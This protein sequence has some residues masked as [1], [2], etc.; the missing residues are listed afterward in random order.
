MTEER[1][2]PYF[3]LALG[4]WTLYQAWKGV[5]PD[6]FNPWGN[7]ETGLHMRREQRMLF[8]FGGL[9]VTFVGLYGLYRRFF[10]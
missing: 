7:R 6:S 3:Y 8:G 9:I 5:V 1:W 2:L 10:G 4:L